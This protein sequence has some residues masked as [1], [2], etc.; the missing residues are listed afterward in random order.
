[1]IAA[2]YTSGRLGHP[3][4]ETATTD[5]EGQYRFS[6]SVE[7]GRAYRVVAGRVDLS[8]EARDPVNLPTYYPDGLTLEDAAPILLS[9]G[10]RREGVN[11]RLR[12]GPTFCVSGQYRMPAEAMAGEFRLWDRDG[13]ALPLPRFEK[14]ARSYQI[15]GLPSGA[16]RF[17]V[18]GVI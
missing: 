12:R 10:E 13:F 1:L 11:I 3:I 5:S 7:T 14:S 8:S 15:C 6:R 9:A 4:A 18:N 2:E 17:S 16:Y